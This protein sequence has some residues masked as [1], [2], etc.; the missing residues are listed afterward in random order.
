MRSLNRQAQQRDCSSHQGAWGLGL[1][2]IRHHS[3]K[4]AELYKLL[5]SSFIFSSGSSC[6]AHRRRPRSSSSILKCAC[7]AGT[8]RSW[9][10]RPGPEG[11]L[12]LGCDLAVSHVLEPQ[13]CSRAH[14]EGRLQRD[15]TSPAKAT[16]FFSEWG[17]KCLLIKHMGFLGIFEIP[18]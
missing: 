18:L 16:S 17:L 4:L 5:S 7:G 12:P 13:T 11:T 14:G 1:Q 6:S 9:T 2:V 8:W 3:Q 15:V 10:L